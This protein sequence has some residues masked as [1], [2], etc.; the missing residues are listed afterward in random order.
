MNKKILS[1]ILAAALS[2]STLAF[3]AEENSKV[4]ISF[5][6]GD[7]ILSIN[8]AKTE[9]ETP[10]IAGAGTTLVPLRV[11][12]ESFA[13]GGSGSFSKWRYNGSFEIYIR[14]FRCNCKL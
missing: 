4:E 1:V 10:Y 13:A 3:A 12:T 6:V 9:V 7:S 2:L 11:I 5:K 8:G 14:N